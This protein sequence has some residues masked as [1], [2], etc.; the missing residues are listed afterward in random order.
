MNTVMNISIRAFA[1]AGLLVL[2]SCGKSGDQKTTDKTAAG[3]DKAPAATVS[4]SDAPLKPVLQKAGFEPVFYRSFPGAVPGLASSMLVYRASRGSGG[5]VLFLQEYGDQFPC[6]WHWYFADDAP[7]SVQAVEVNE[8][9]LWD[10]RMFVKGQPRDYIQDQS[11]TLSARQRDDL[12]AMN[13]GASE[14]VDAAGMSWF[15]F[16]GD[17]AT[18]W[19]SKLG[20]AYI[21]V[22]VP[23]GAGTTLSIQLLASDQPRKVELKADGKKV[24]EFELDATTLEQ[25]VQL[26]AAAQGASV[27][28]LEFKSGQDG[29]G[30]V[31]VAE[32]G[33]R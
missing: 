31:A 3:T 20:G 30:N 4:L 21:E 33:V 9:G 28:R 26:D 27:L 19:R 12:I 15:A 11:F 25:A 16:D 24:Q 1:V 6:V 14:P 22:P 2:A 13:G 32:L 8:D 29:A 17:T 5:G 7:D 18:A 10:V 23:L